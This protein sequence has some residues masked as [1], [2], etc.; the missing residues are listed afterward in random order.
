MPA[1]FGSLPTICTI[2]W[3]LS[4]P[5]AFKTATIGTY[6]T[7]LSSNYKNNTLNKV[8]LIKV[9]QTYD[10]FKL[11]W[12]LIHWKSFK[13]KQYS[14]K[15]KHVFTHTSSVKVLSRR[16]M[17]SCLTIMFVL[18]FLSWV[19]L[20]T[21]AVTLIQKHRK[22]PS[23]YVQ[24]YKYSKLQFVNWAIRTILKTSS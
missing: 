13:Q 12:K 16:Y 4:V 19:L 24:V 10:P 14:A 9:C 15:W 18:L 20:V 11:I 1:N 8:L 17:R 3:S 6:S 22:P 23:D 5:I 21:D 2:S 7:N